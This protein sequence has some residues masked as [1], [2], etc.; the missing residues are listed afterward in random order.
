MITSEKTVRYEVHTIESAPPGGGEA[1]AGLKAAVGVIPNLA[2]TMAESP[3]LLKGFLAL[4]QLYASTGFSPGGDPGTLARRTRSRS[5]D[6]R[7]R[8][9][10]RLMFHTARALKELGWN[11]RRARGRASVG[12]RQTP[13]DDDGS[14]ALTEFAR[15]PIVRTRG[16][17]EVANAL[18]RFL[19]AGFSRRPGRS[20]SRPRH[21]GYAQDA[22]SSYCRPPH[23]AGPRRLPA[24]P[25]RGRA[26]S[27]V[28]STRRESSS[29]S[30]RATPIIR[31][32]RNGL[33]APVLAAW[34]PNL[35]F[36]AAGLYLIFTL[37]T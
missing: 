12:R 9:V 13:S 19:A 7:S 20:T 36:S 32:W 1:L 8:E 14:V 4:R 21:A 25:T 22:R 30:L 2:A 29:G 24:A 33:Q 3:E 15:T 27:G 26:R 28:D 23:G 35:L 6:C 17:V 10:L 16:H 37:E 34:A 5:N 31:A 18:E 11:R